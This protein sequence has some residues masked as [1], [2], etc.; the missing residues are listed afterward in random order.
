[1]YRDLIGD[2]ERFTAGGKEWWLQQFCHGD[3]TLKFVRLYDAD[4]EFVGEFASVED[5]LS[6][7]A[8]AHKGKE[9]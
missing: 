3:G 1:M 6:C 4:G 7:A 9:G 2:P 8:G 5:A